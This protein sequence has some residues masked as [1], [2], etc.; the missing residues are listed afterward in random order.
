MD[1]LQISNV[2]KEQ[3]I[4]YRDELCSQYLPNQTVIVQSSEKQRILI[5]S[6]HNLVGL[7]NDFKTLS[8]QCLRFA[9]IAL[10]QYTYPLCDFDKQQ[11]LIIRKRMVVI[12]FLNFNLNRKFLIYSI[13]FFDLKN[14][15]AEKIVKCLNIQFVKQSMNWR[16]YKI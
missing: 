7:I 5:K 3:C 4:L 2:D 15:C 9:M 11:N 16:N 10:C 6:L 14:R 8:F 12:I 1:Y 13:C